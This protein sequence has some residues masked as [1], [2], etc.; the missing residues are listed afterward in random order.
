MKNKPLTIFLASAF[1]VL[2]LVGGLYYVN[3][4]K[5]TNVATKTPTNETAEKLKMKNSVPNV[6][7]T[8]N[9]TVPNQNGVVQNNGKNSTV[10]PKTTNPQKNIE[11]NN[12]TQNQNAP[13][14]TVP[15]PVNPAP[16]QPAPNQ[17]TADE[18]NFLSNVE[19]LIIQQVNAQ[20]TNAGVASVSF[21]QSLQHYARI[22]SKDMGDNNY[23][24]HKDLNG[25]LITAKMQADG[26][27]FSAWGE[28]IAYI[29][30]MTDANQLANTFMNQWMN[31]AGHRANILSTNFTNIGVGVYKI[32]D[33]V[34]ATQEFSR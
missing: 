33:K 23:F 21:N 4:S 31:S 3:K 11:P 10:V 32:G 27:S 14:K 1:G 7:N 17:A 20:R 15:A 9:Q 26:F 24:D 25:Q 18:Q 2:I 6:D 22:K 30:G 13:A 8:T 29:T 5:N 19:Q 16:V 34:Y 12:V 28:N